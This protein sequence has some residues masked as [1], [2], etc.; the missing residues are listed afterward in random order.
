MKNGK[1]I[2]T[3][4]LILASFNANAGLYPSNFEISYQD[5]FLELE[6]NYFNLPI[7]VMPDK[8]QY[9]L[10]NSNP[11]DAFRNIVTAYLTGNNQWLKANY[12]GE[13]EDLKKNTAKYKKILKKQELYL[14]GFVIFK[15]YAV[16]F[17]E[18][19]RTSKKMLLILEDK[20]DGYK[21]CF[22]FKQKYLNIYKTIY[23]AYQRNGLFKV[24]KNK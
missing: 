19:R 16:L 21:L 12:I 10:N 20:G 7:V 4:C 22:N 17:I 24:I 6:G 8:N 18:T 9:Q 15:N 14:H 5:T 11:V 13:L 23:Q 2:I 3:I 1:I